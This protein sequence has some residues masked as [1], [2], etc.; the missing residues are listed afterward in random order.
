MRSGPSACG[1]RQPKDHIS[2]LNIQPITPLTCRRCA[3]AI[4][5]S[6]RGSR[7]QTMT[8]AGGRLLRSWAVAGDTRVSETNW[9]GRETGW[10]ATLPSLGGAPRLLKYQRVCSFA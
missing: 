7:A 1:S 5:A 8:T 2:V 3:Y 4:P 6:R 10:G 9:K